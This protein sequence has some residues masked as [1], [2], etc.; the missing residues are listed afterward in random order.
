[1]VTEGNTQKDTQQIADPKAA[2]ETKTSTSTPEIPERYRG[3]S[4]EE[5]IKMHEEATRL[6]HGSTQEAAQAKEEAADLRKILETVTPMIANAN[7]GPE[8]SFEE[9]YATDPEKAI[10][11][12]IARRGRPLEGRVFKALVDLD[13]ANCKITYGKDFEKNLPAVKRL[14]QERP[15]LT[16]RGNA[17]ETGYLIL[18]GRES[19][20]IRTQAL[21][22]GNKAT[23]TTQAE[24][25]V[26][27]AGKKT[28]PTT[29]TDSEL[30]AEANETGNWEKVIQ[31]KLFPK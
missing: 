11:Q 12:E 2:E 29:P 7:K 4:P 8:Q 19:E 30:V 18:K 3:K 17:Y 20:E 24:T 31:S 22:E 16:Q 1:M 26:E 21:K 28:T 9:L 6:M 27:G 14:L 5:L 10:K 13:E 25:F 23:T 15:E